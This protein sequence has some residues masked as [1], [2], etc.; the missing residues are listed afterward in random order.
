MDIH[1]HIYYALGCKHLSREYRSALND[2]EQQIPNY[3]VVI[4][5]VTLSPQRCLSCHK[6]YATLTRLTLHQRK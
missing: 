1:I 3:A 5:S 4:G 2:S 6:K